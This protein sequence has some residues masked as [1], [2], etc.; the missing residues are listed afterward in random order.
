MPNFFDYPDVLKEE[1]LKLGYETD[2]FDDRPSSNPWVKAIVRINR[3]LINHY[4]EKY[5]RQMM[6]VVSKKSY[7]VVF[8]ISGQS[9][10]F[11][12]DMINELREVQPN[13]KFVLYQWDSQK[14]FP[15]IIKMQKYFDE[16]YSFDKNDVDNNSR[17]KFLP[18]FYSNSYREIGKMNTK[19]FKF[20]FSF[21]GTAHPKKYK[22]VKK[23]SEQLIR[24]YPN[25]FIYFFYPSRIV[26]FYRKIFSKELK[27]AQYSEFHF[28]SMSREEISKIYEESRC[29]LDSAQSG[30]TGLTIR[31]I[32]SLGAKR[33]LITT[34]KDIVNYDF[35][36]PENI[37]IYQDEI[38]FDDIFFKEEYVD[39]KS[40]IYEKYSVNNW[41]KK[42]LE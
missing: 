29:I 9:L 39:I 35:Y 25:Q 41:L 36:T 2:F 24:V 14:N 11:N 34:N 23:M 15:Y 42:I 37:Y 28:N 13:S 20:D 30:Q 8:L 10:S 22:F 1:L 12:E 31:A 26:Y 4:I 21:V 3:D 33:K 18:L 19:N 16:C 17:L 32:E 6:E 7:D 38:D 40:H 27:R 5:F